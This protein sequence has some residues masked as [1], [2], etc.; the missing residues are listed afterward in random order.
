L[1]PHRECLVVL[2]DVSLGL[3]LSALV[4]EMVFRRL[5][6]AV[7]PGPG[8]ARLIASSL[9]FGLIHWGHGYGHMV[10]TAVFGLGLGAVYLG[11]GSLRLVF[12]AHYAV[13]FL[14]FGT[15]AGT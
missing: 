3:L 8:W 15:R 1:A 10:E 5:A 9:L 13:N 7:L 14:A 4:E 6:L 12:A 2:L 11:T